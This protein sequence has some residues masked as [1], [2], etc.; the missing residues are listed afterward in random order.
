[1]YKKG[2]RGTGGRESSSDA[3]QDTSVIAAGGREGARLV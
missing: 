3:W 1:M 2:V